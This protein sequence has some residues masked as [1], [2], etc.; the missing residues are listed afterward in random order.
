MEGNFKVRL[1]VS[2]PNYEVKLIYIK[3]KIYIFSLNLPK[4]IPFISLF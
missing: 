1:F 4:T 3:K 2:F